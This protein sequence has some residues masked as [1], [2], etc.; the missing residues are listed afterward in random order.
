MLVL[1]LSIVPVSYGQWQNPENQMLNDS[2]SSFFYYSNNRPV[3][4][5]D[6]QSLIDTNNRSRISDNY[7]DESEYI[8]EEVRQ[9]R[10]M[11]SGYNG[12]YRPNYYYQYSPNYKL[13]YLHKKKLK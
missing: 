8:L 10:S 7:H 5:S 2:V 13:H 3:P 9:Q 1:Y 12:S 6:P 4:F 11:Q